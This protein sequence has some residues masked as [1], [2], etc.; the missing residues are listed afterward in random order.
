MNKP[1]YTRY[2]WAI[3]LLCLT[4]GIAQTSP[5]AVRI[6]NGI[7]VWDFT[8]QDGK[9][10]IATNAMTN[11]VEWALNQCKQCQD[12]IVQ[13][14]KLASIAAHSDNENNIANNADLLKNLKQKLLKIAKVVVIGTL[15]K[16]DA[17]PTVDLQLTFN[18]L[19][20]TVILANQTITLSRTDAF[21]NDQG[22]REIIAYTILY[23][24]LKIEKPH[25]NNHS[26]YVATGATTFSL[27]S[28]AIGWLTLQKIKSN[29]QSYLEENTNRDPEKNYASQNR[30]YKLNQYVAVGGAVA[31]VAFGTWLTKIAL[32]KR[33]FNRDN[34]NKRYKK[35]K[36]KWSFQ[37]FVPLVPMQNGIGIGFTCQF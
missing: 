30:K 28:A 36:S 6:C 20:S 7:Y 35:P 37:E 5:E 17:K 32:Q 2:L 13:R 34:A 21:D 11:A 3:C 14:R 18:D 26:L 15:T 22:L 25:F 1:R 12:Q 4:K 29:W 23:E 31:T 33:Q 10:T 16:D 9:K 8:E 19:N 24:V 27:S